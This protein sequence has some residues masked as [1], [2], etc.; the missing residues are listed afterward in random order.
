MDGSNKKR[1][2]KHC[3]P[4]PHPPKKKNVKTSPKMKK[5]E[6]SRKVKKVKKK[7]K[8]KK[9]KKEARKEYR[10]SISARS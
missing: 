2:V 8:E 1:E 6:K 4:T 9:E 3:H 5:E 7:K 10:K